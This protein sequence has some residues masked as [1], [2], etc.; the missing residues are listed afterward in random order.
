MSIFDDPDDDDLS[1]ELL[2]SAGRDDDVTPD[3]VT[4]LDSDDLI[5]ARDPDR[6]LWALATSGAQVRRAVAAADIWSKRLDADF[7]PRAALV[8]T[9]TTA[10]V[11]ASILGELGGD[12]TAVID[13]R[14]PSLPRWAGPADV[15]LAASIDGRHPRVAMLVAEAQRRGL[16]VVVA[17]PDDTPVGA[18]AGRETHVAIDAPASRRASL[19]TLLTPL[20]LAGSALGFVP[21]SAGQLLGVADAM[22]DVAESSRPASDAFTNAAKQLAIEVIETEAIIAGVGPFAAH[23]A[24]CMT[25]ALALM[26][27]ITA[28][29]VSLPDDVTRAGALIDLPIGSGT[30]SSSAQD[31]FRDRVEEPGRR[32]RLLF[33]S[34]TGPDGA[35]PE[36]RE[37]ASGEGLTRAADLAAIAL[38]HVAASRGILSSTLDL[39]GE[40]PLSRFAA[41]ALFGDFT[42][43][44][45]A[46]GRGVDPT[47][48]RAGEL[49]H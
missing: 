33:I 48:A 36:Q 38:E 12:R 46:I 35:G 25:H 1:A 43:A 44:Y 9:D 40:S 41:A 45:A 20:L 22:D 28:V 34:D 24:V 18:A 31:F 8:V 37:S 11:A 49:P 21:I 16:R 19:W 23:A 42:A 6:L 32:R 4:I 15:L 14:G 3:V 29:P 13:W 10:S 39:P 17:A 30:D 27:G 7:T 2:G 5:S 47:A 26:A